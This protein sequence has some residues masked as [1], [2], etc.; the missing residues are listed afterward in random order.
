[1]IDNL[2][3]ALFAIPIALGIAAGLTFIGIFLYYA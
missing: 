1:M 3:A 2:I